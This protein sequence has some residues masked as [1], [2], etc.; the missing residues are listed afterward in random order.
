[1]QEILS[2]QSILKKTVQV[3]GNTLVSRFLGLTREILLMR[4]LGVGVVADA[5]TAAFL[6]PNSL[7]KIF[8]E[9]A[10]TA[11]FVPTFIKVHQKEGREKADALMSLAFLAFE[12]SVLLLCAIVMWK[13]E[14]AISIVAPGFSQEQVAATIPCLR[15]LMPFIFFISSS[16]LL[17]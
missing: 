11:A 4:F 6:I 16:A 7:R 2:K 17:S 9:G 13:A 10:L 14:V 8:A 1:M 5:F 3:G 12:G 15:I